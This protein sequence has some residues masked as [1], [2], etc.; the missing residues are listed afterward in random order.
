MEKVSLHPS[1]ALCDL[2][3]DARPKPGRAADLREDLRPVRLARRACKQRLLDS[4]VNVFVFL[5]QCVTSCE[6]AHGLCEHNN[7][8]VRVY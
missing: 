4:A 1:P 8:C 7:V 3:L 2:L 6:H 5:T